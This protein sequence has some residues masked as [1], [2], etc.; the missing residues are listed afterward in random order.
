MEP[1]SIPH[2]ERRNNKRTRIDGAKASF[3]PF[4]T[5]LLVYDFMNLLSIAWQKQMYSNWLLV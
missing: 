1:S 4:R 2:P 5:D 3:S